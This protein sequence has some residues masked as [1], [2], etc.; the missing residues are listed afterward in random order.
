[1]EIYIHD[2]VFPATCSGG[3]PPSAGSKNS[4]CNLISKCGPHF[5]TARLWC[6]VVAVQYCQCCV[7]RQEEPRRVTVTSDCCAAVVR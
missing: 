5:V 7:S 3:R 4:Y 2:T 1:M 6:T